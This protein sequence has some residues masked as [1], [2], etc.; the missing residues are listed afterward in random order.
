MKYA[1]HT[2]IIGLLIHFVLFNRLTYIIQIPPQVLTVLSL[3]KEVLIAAIMIQVIYV[4]TRQQL[5]KRVVSDRLWM[6]GMIVL[7]VTLIIVACVSMMKGIAFSHLLLAFKYD[8]LGFLLGL[9]MYQVGVL[10]PKEQ[11]SQIITSYIQ[12]MKWL[13]ILGLVWYSVIVIKPGILKLFGYDKFVYEGTIGSPP[14]AVYYS[15][16]DHGVQRNQFLFERPISY[17]FRLVAFWPLFRAVVLRKHPLR[18]TWFWWMMYGFNVLS[19]FSRA[20]RLARVI[21]IILLGRIVY[22][23]HFRQH[24]FKVMLPLLIIGGGIAYY[25]YSQGSRQFSNTGHITALIQ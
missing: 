2:L 22:G 24:F 17:G 8:F 9:V 14:P 20:A 10:L 25:G 16:Y 21:Q 5:W 6:G 12:W 7:S 1:I 11:V 3:R 19:T 18:E 4:I 15:G 13:L 23:K